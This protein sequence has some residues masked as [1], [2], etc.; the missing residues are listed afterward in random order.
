MFRV[1]TCVASLHCVPYREKRKAGARKKRAAGFGYDFS[2]LARV[3]GD[4]MTLITPLGAPVI[5]VQATP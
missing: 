3:S 4:V 2:G 1:S 5:A